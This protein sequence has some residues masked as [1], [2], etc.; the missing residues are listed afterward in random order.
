VPVDDEADL[1]IATRLR[2][3]DRLATDKVRC[4]ART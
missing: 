1:G 4:S 3:L 2:L